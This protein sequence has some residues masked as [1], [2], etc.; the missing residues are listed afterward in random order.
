[1]KILEVCSL[2]VLILY[3]LICERPNARSKSVHRTKENG[4]RKCSNFQYAHHSVFLR[5][6]LSC[7]TTEPVT[8]RLR[9]S[10]FVRCHVS[11]ASCHL[12][13]VGSGQ[14]MFHNVLLL[15]S[16]VLQILCLQSING[17]IK[18]PLNFDFLDQ[19]LRKWTQEGH[20]PTTMV[21]CNNKRGQ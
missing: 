14:Q 10:L 11:F 20:K 12:E 9:C 13:M 6:N 8:S 17:S 16:A 15:S 5:F 1:M 21:I 4:E 2:R 18:S 3:H 19:E 7:H